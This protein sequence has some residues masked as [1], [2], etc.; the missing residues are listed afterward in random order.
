MA[1]KERPLWRLKFAPVSKPYVLLWKGEL[2]AIYPL[3]E[4]ENASEVPQGRQQQD[5]S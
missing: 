5:A 1:L 2:V 3:K 4:R